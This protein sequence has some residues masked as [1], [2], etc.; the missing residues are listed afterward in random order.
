MEYGKAYYDW[1]KEIG[2][3]GAEADFFKIED[4]LAETPRLSL[5]S[6]VEGDSGLQK[7]EPV[8]FSVLRSILLPGR[9]A[10]SW[11]SP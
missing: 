1:Q 6:D 10:R 5:S 8:E 2:E 3:F 11:E 9:T 4:L 7:L